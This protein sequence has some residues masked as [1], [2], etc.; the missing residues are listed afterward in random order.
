MRSGYEAEPLRA[1]E[2]GSPARHQSPSRKAISARSTAQWRRAESHSAACCWSWRPIIGPEAAEPHEHSQ[3]RSRSSSCLPPHPW[4]PQPC[5]ASAS[6]TSTRAPS[7]TWSPGAAAISAHRAGDRRERA[8]APS[9]SLRP[10][11]GAGPFSTRSPSATEEARDD[12]AVHG[13]LHEAAGVEMLEVDPSRGRTGRRGSGGRRGARACPRRP[14]SPRRRSRPGAASRRGSPPPGLGV[15]GEQRV[16]PLAVDDGGERGAP[17]AISWKPSSA[18]HGP[19]WSA[20]ATSA[21]SRAARHVAATSESTRRRSG[22]PRSRLL[23]A[24]AHERPPRNTQKRFG[25]SDEARCPNVS[26]AGTRDASTRR[27]RKPPLVRGPATTVRRPAHANIS[28]LP[29]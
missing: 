12:L 11:R 7:A 5:S 25:G 27:F 6:I 22:R 10:P 26:A 24:R 17:L 23:R 19:A 9:S 4:P 21:A 29:T 15:E 20:M 3:P 14:R 18:N 1:K 16:E 13:G 2:A 28:T 8:G